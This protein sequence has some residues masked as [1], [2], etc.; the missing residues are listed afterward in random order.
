MPINAP[1][2]FRRAVGQDQPLLLLVLLGGAVYVARI[3]WADLRATQ[4]GQPPRQPLPGAAPAGRLA[5]A[6]AVGGALAIL[7]AETAAEYALGVADRQ[8]RMTVLFGCYTLAA[9]VIEEVIFRGYVVVE[10]RGRAALVAGCLGASVL[11][12][13]LHPFLWQWRDGSLVWDFSAKGWVSTG[14]VLAASLWFYTVRFWALNPTRSLL[15]CF[16]AHLAKNA[17]VFAI[18][19]AQGY[20]VGW[21]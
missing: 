12:A 11:F 9:A 7:A 3:W 13:A 8:S 10:G 16:A 6:L 19:A 1:L 21:W 5:V 2:L 18:K 4:A 15:P 14:A 17:G 20:V